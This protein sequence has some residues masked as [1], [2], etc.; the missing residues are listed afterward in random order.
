MLSV[1]ECPN[2]DK[3]EVF[4]A[5][6]LVESVIDLLLKPAISTLRLQQ[7]NADQQ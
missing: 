3:K 6:Q 5:E 2:E 7:Y 1:I 4:A